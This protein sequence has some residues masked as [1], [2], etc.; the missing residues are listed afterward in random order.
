MA[1]GVQV[2]KL[3]EL[4]DHFDFNCVLSYYAD[5]RLL[6]WLETRYYDDEAE[7]IKTLDKNAPDFNKNLCDILGVKY[8]EEEAAHASLSD[9]SEKNERL[10]ELRKH[11][12]DNKILAAVDSVAFTQEDL[13]RLVNSGKDTVYLCGKQFIIPENE[14]VTYI[15]VDTPPKVELPNGFISLGIKHKNV[16]T[17]V[18]DIISQAKACKDEVERAKLWRTAAE[19]GDAEA[20]FELACCYE[21][22]IGVEQSETEMIKWYGESAEQGNEKA[23]K[24]LLQP[25]IVRK[26]LDGE[27]RDLPFGDYKW[28][29][30]E[31]QE[32]YALIIT[33]NIVEMRE[34]DT[35]E[36]PRGET[37]TWETC[38][39]RQYLNND[40]FNKFNE[41]CRNKILTAD[42]L[43]SGSKNYYQGSFSMGKIPLTVNTKD[44]IFLL[45]TDE[46]E[47]HFRD[48]SERIAREPKGEAMLWWLRSFAD[49]HACGVSSGGGVNQGIE[50]NGYK[51]MRYIAGVRPALWLSLGNDIKNVKLVVEAD[52]VNNKDSDGSDVFSTIDSIS[53][54]ELAKQMQ[55]AMGTSSDAHSINY[56]S[57][58]KYNCDNCNGSLKGSIFKG[59][60]CSECGKVYGGAPG[61]AEHPMYKK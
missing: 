52:S 51:S 10:N 26:I 53:N 2:R 47:K 45:S 14:G 57:T 27:R 58:T 8:S 15:G 59:L 60:H 34:Y 49:G 11:T 46:A 25:I 29:V 9:A 39:L 24:L 42:I 17:N 31:I 38:A 28:Q 54:E 21:K 48:N 20:Q 43:T 16:K 22:G 1:D 55:K 35:Q 33:M 4:R 37:A 32:D 44:K 6:E 3:E 13:M 5:G 7:K 61:Y 19:M 50:I 40:F 36:Y 56:S 41:Q 30:L 23:Q 12:A 18:D